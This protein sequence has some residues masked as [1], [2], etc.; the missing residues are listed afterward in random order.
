MRAE[1]DALRAHHPWVAIVGQSLGGALALDAAATSAEVR[2][3]VLLAPW[4]AMPTLLRALAGTSVVWGPL[5]PYVPS[6]GS[7]SIHDPV[8][9]SRALTQGLVTPELLAAEPQR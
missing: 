7:Q 4:V 3:L 5:I 2:A 8:A 9:R 6:L 1:I